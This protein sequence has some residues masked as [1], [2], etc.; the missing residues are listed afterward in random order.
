MAHHNHLVHL[1][2]PDLSFVNLRWQKVP[3]ALIKYLHSIT[4]HKTSL[5]KSKNFRHLLDCDTTGYI[6]V[7]FV[8]VSGWIESTDILHNFC[9]RG[10]HNG[11]S[12]AAALLVENINSSSLLEIPDNNSVNGSAYKNLNEWKV[13]SWNTKVGGSQNKRLLFISNYYDYEMWCFERKMSAL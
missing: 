9:S 7:L 13:F 11:T 1:N 4:Y 5:P 12:S 8:E 2:Y 3:R 10:T 6:W